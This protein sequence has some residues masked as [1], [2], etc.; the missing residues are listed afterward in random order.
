MQGSRSKAG[1]MQQLQSPYLGNMNSGK[2]YV[3]TTQAK[4]AL[5]KKRE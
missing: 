5:K 1:G 2:V 4:A 3:N